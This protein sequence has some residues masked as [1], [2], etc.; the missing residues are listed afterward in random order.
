MEINERILKING[1]VNIS[2]GL[3]LDTDYSIMITGGC[4][5]KEQ[6][7]QEDGTSNMVYKIKPITIDLIDKTGKKVPTKDKGSFSKKWRNFI[8]QM[9]LDYDALAE[10]QWQYREEILE[11]I[12]KLED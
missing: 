12:K 2:E 9:G 1:S 4:Y 10:K 6:V 7:S 11:F 5:R 3:E 8:W